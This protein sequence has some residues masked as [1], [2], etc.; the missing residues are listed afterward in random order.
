MRYATGILAVG[1]I[2]VAGLFSFHFSSAQGGAVPNYLEQSLYVN[3][4]CAK[5]WEEEQKKEPKDQ[6]ETGPE[7]LVW[8]KCSPLIGQG[9]GAQVA[10]AVLA[11]QCYVEGHC[12]RDK[13]KGEGLPGL[14]VEIQPQDLPPNA[15]TS[16][17][18]PNTP[19]IPNT[20]PNAPSSSIQPSDI[21][22]VPP[23]T[24]V[25]TL[26]P[27][28]PVSTPPPNAP[29]SSPPP[30][31][32]TSGGGVQPTLPINPQP[33]LPSLL[34][35]TSVGEVPS[36]GLQPGGMFGNPYSSGSTFG[37]G[38]FSSGSGS[39]SGNGFFNFFA[40]LANWLSGLGARSSRGSSNTGS[41]FPPP[42]PA[43]QP[44][45][46]QIAQ[47]PDINQRTE[48]MIRRLQQREDVQE[49]ARRA[50][51]EHRKRI[52]DALK[53]GAPGPLDGGWSDRSGLP[54]PGQKTPEEQL[55]DDAERASN[56][57][58][59]PGAVQEEQEN[60]LPSS[61][62]SENGSGGT[63][64]SANEP[65]TRTDESPPLPKHP[66][67]WPQDLERKLAEKLEQGYTGGEALHAAGDEYADDVIRGLMTGDIAG[68][69]EA[70][71]TTRRLLQEKVGGATSARDRYAISAFGE[72]ELIDSLP[73]LPDMF[74]SEE[75]RALNAALGRQNLL[76]YAEGI[77]KLRQDVAN[78][79]P[80]A[81]SSLSPKQAELQ[82]LAK[83]YNDLSQQIVNA[84]EAAGWGTRLRGALLPESLEPQAI[85]EIKAMEK[86]LANMEERIVA[87][88]R[89]NDMGL[90][91]SMKLG[92]PW[93]ISLDIGGAV[94]PNTPVSGLPAS[95]AETP[96]AGAEFSSFPAE[97]IPPEATLGSAAPPTPPTPPAQ[98]TPQPAT[99]PL[100]VQ[101][102]QPPAQP[103]A[104]PSASQ[105]PPSAPSA[106]G[107]GPAPSASSKPSGGGFIQ[108][109]LDFLN[110]LLQ[111][112]LGFFTGDSNAGEGNSF[113]PQPPPQQQPPQQT[114]LPSAA[115]TANPSLLDAGESTQLS[116]SSVG[117]PKCAIVD[118]LLNVIA[119]GVNG[120][121]SSPSLQESSR[122][123]II[124][125]IEGGNDKFVN[126]TLVR[127]DGDDTD[128]PPL[129][130]HS[131]PVS[132]AA[133]A[134][135]SGPNDS[136]GTS[137]GGGTGSG[138][139]GGSSNAPQPIDVR[140]CDP[141]QPID[142]FIRCLCEAEP[143]PA[144]CTI[145]PGG[146]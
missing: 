120:T 41:S 11:Q 6:K 37:S 124:C 25:T 83:N 142:S 71:G 30:S 15:Q 90:T 81:D 102:P 34:P 46:T 77:A 92:E 73:W 20:N 70:V 107:S 132:Q 10:A 49:A 3:E 79:V 82:E 26:D 50:E 91:Y 16:P 137:A 58:F 63:Q 131:G 121:A 87:F 127:V 51:E 48:D 113:S 116:W 139:T 128:P 141:E 56:P 23:D 76:G 86:A 29:V 62:R 60:L 101:K 105:P 98:P 104:P 7:C 44:P 135:G 112:L 134:S 14:P 27:N 13:C 144:G 47:A 2:V 130:S 72:R 100:P 122:F 123:G 109:G 80:R 129:F 12:L 88:A 59:P 24:N 66:D 33:L 35:N 52:E 133:P 38:D 96:S 4:Q 114:T 19:A 89:E 21:Y 45:P 75:Q 36:G 115:I 145:P 31:S 93:Q 43:P 97:T 5:W 74:K 61:P 22:P 17:L 78:G 1:I 39:A 69:A 117:S 68:D 8:V 55:R 53:L 32:V 119:S 40:G 65:G 136:S 126:E 67:W 28:A 94:A 99:P 110:A 143:N 54:K 85:A 118:A 103:A 42:R 140:T 84:K 9:P 138:G 106:P 111:S 146:I 108:G 125:D 95:T 18:D 57:V 64:T